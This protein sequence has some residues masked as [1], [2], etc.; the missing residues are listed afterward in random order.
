MESSRGLD[1]SGRLI[2]V[3]MMGRFSDLHV[4]VDPEHRFIGPDT[5]P[6]CSTDLCIFYGPFCLSLRGVTELS[7]NLA[8]F[9]SLTDGSSRMESNPSLPGPSPPTRSSAG[10]E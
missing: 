3:L 4:T 5:S 10:C 6:L 2:F 1:D 9:H 7:A 8:L